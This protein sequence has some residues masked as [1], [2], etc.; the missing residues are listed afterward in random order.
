VQGVAGHVT[1]LAVA[2]AFGKAMNLV[3]GIAKPNVF[4][5]DYLLA[6]AWQYWQMHG[7]KLPG[8]V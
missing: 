6:N 1:L 5:N 2:I 4:V 3:W 8:P 7:S